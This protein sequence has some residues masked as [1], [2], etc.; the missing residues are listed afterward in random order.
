M[1]RFECALCGFSEKERAERG[2][3]NSDGAVGVFEKRLSHQQN[4]D[5]L[6]WKIDNSTASRGTTSRGGKKKGR[7]GLSH[8][9][10]DLLHIVC[11]RLSCRRKRSQDTREDR[12]VALGGRGKQRHFG[13]LLRPRT[14]P[15]A[16]KR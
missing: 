13:S 11:L 12:G 4:L 3:G 8:I 9:K 6:I 5:W 10:K 15:M 7:E 1:V 16:R 14:P 2:G